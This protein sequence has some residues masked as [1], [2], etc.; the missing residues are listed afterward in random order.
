V[1]SQV[2]GRYYR[3]VTVATDKYVMSPIAIVTEGHNNNGVIIATGLKIP[4]ARTRHYRDVMRM[5]FC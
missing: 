3:L 4:V 1:T 5:P 2:T